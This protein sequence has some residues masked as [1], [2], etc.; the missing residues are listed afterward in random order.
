[1]STLNSH[2]SFTSIVLELVFADWAVEFVWAEI[3]DGDEGE[4]GEV[5]EGLVEM[6]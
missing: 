2:G 3:L 5:C 6:G 1:M 4:S